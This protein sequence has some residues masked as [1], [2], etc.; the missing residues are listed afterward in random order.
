M[1]VAPACVLAFWLDQSCA[2]HLLACLL[3]EWS[4]M[5]KAHLLEVSSWEGKVS[6]LLLEV[7]KQ[8]T[9]CLS[10]PCLVFC[11]TLT[12]S[13]FLTYLTLSPPVWSCI[14]LWETQ[15][16]QGERR[17]K[18]DRKIQ[19]KIHEKFWNKFR[20]EEWAWTTLSH[21]LV[22]LISEYLCGKELEI[23]CPEVENHPC[24]SAFDFNR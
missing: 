21:H 16:N 5:C 4:V 18:S 10:Q 9:T 22:T 6:C 15:K 24:S 12:W 2:M 23:W 11:E 13:N 17:E 8:L 3:V 20:E 14:N 7:M 19:R 1:W